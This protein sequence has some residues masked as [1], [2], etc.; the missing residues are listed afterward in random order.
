M[1]SLETLVHQY[2]ETW[3]ETDAA[4]RRALIAEVYAADAGYTD[5]VVELTGV[6]AIDAFI[7][8]VQEKYKG[9]EFRL[10]GPIDAHHEQ[11]RFT[12]HAGLPNGEPSYIGFDV[13]VAENGR[14]RNVYGFLDKVPAQSAPAPY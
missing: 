8:N 11:A 10:G 2:I 6:S 5:P 7:A 12:W 14:L 4:R 9:V 1:S 3:N 13:A